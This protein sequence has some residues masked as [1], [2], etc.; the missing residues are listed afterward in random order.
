[1]TDPLYF[2]LST[3]STPAA[4][5]APLLPAV[6]DKPLPLSPAPTTPLK[7]TSP[8]VAKAAQGLLS[9]GFITTADGVTSFA[10]PTNI[11]NQS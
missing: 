6:S 1:M 4:T 10:A 9:P 2:P 8:S 5:A 3:L 7:P 11:M